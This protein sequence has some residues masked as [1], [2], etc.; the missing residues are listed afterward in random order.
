MLPVP[1]P[2]CAPG[3]PSGPH[4]AGSGT[5]TSEASAAS[6]AEYKHQLGVCPTKNNSDLFFYTINTFKTNSVICMSIIAAFLSWWT[7]C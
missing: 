5:V 7:G 6:R 2:P 3:P 1:A 4:P